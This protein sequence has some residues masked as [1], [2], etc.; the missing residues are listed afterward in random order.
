VSS[1]D[2]FL[3]RVRR[4]L[5]KQPVPSEMRPPLLFA[6]PQLQAKAIALHEGRQTQRAALISQLQQQ[7]TAVGGVV[8]CVA[9]VAEATDYVT[10]LAQEKHATTVVRWQSEILQDLEVDAALHQQGIAVHVAAPPADQGHGASQADSTLA[11]TRRTMRQLVAQADLGLSGIDY[12]IAETGTLAL[13]ALPGHMRG[14]SLLPPVHVAVARAEQIV[15]TMADVLLLLRAAGPDLQHHLSS[16]ISFITG[17]S[18]TGDIELTLTVGVHGPGEL[19]LVILDEA[20][21]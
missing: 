8:T 1:Q 2:V 20:S 21:A 3:S 12:A 15:A 4:A 6:E 14:V 7:L 17:P 9:S 19:H 11:E 5:R 16:C 10:R 18:R 13:S